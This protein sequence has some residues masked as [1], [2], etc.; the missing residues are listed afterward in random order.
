MALVRHLLEYLLVRVFVCVVQALRPETC[1][2]VAGGL[3]TLAC[4]VLRLRRSVI[5]ENF[6]IAF[7]EL[8]AAG[9]RR[10]EWQMWEHLFLMIA[11]IAHAPRRIHRSNWR[12]L[13]HVSDLPRIVGL[14]LDKR[15]KVIVAGHFGNFE[16]SGYVL[17]LLGFPTFTVARPLDNPYLDRFVHRFRSATGQHMLSKHGS[18]AEIDRMLSGGGMLAVLGDQAAGPK[19]CW[20]NFFGRPASTHK[21]VAV[22]ALANDAPLALGYARRVGLFLEY[23]LGLA[24]VA[25]PQQMSAEEASVHGLSQWFNHQLERVVRLAP[26][27]YWWVHRRWKGEGP[28]RKLQ[29]AA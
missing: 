4:R 22:F 11:E 2:T 14:L 7:P 10:L 5:D 12:R 23:E 24:G 1:R 18:S 15:P 3:A 25:D 8:S 6:A 29:R 9:R 20:V 21:A 19:G 28:R 26:E 17:G 16:L 13:I 27:Q